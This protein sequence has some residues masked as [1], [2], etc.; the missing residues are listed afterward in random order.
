MVRRSLKRDRV[1]KT[2]NPEFGPLGVEYKKN[3][4]QKRN[5]NVSYLLFTMT[6]TMAN[7]SLTNTMNA[8]KTEENA[9]V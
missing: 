4:K 2:L 3:G 7:T 8:A 9:T 5:S 6:T 1:N